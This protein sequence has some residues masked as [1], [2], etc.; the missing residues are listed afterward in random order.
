VDEVAPPN[1]EVAVAEDEFDRFQRKVPTV[2]EGDRHPC[3]GPGRAA[4]PFAARPAAAAA[5]GQRQGSRSAAL[6]SHSTTRRASPGRPAATWAVTP[7]RDQGTTQG[8]PTP[9]SRASR[10]T[11]R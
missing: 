4:V 3:L 10:S 7:W 8:S 5:R 1:Q 9:P 6:S 11:A 2:D